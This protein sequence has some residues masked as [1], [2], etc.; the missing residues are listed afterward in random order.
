LNELIDSKVEAEAPLYG[1]EQE[2]TMLTKGGN[3]YG[4]P[5]GGFPAP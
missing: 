4:W 5:S 3:V 1:F 2:Y